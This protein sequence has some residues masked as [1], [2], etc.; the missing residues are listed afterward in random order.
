MSFKGMKNIYLCQDC[1]R[2]HVSQDVDDG[3]TPFMTTCLACA[4]TAVSML[5]RARQEMLAEIP[6]AQEWYRPKAAELAAPPAHTQAHVDKGGLIS[7]TKPLPLNP[8]WPRAK[9]GAK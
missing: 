6:A 5:Y 2:G 4:G 3:V 8:S 1:G 9:A 7:R